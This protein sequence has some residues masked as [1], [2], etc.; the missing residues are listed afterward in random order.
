[1]QQ[2]ISEEFL[3]HPKLNQHL[4]LSDWIYP[5]Y[6]LHMGLDVGNSVLHTSVLIQ[7]YPFEAEGTCSPKGELTCVSAKVLQY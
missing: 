2:Y 4:Y 7:E 3:L 1:M 6:R 5:Q